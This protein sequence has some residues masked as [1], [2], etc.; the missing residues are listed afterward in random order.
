M[1]ND[2]SHGHGGGHGP[3]VEILSQMGYEAR[4]V[5]LNV[6]GR[7]LIFLGI[8]IAAMTAASFFIYKTL[9]PSYAEVEHSPRLPHV[10]TL[11]PY[12]Q[13][14]V[15][16]HR[17]IMEFKQ[18]EED[19]IAGATASVAGGAKT[20]IPISQ[21]IDQMAEKGIAGVS[22]S[23]LRPDSPAYPGSS[24]YTVVVT[25]KADGPP[26]TD[27]TGTGMSAEAGERPSEQPAE[28]GSLPTGLEPG[29]TPAAGGMPVSPSGTS[30]K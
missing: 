18:A 30:A 1:R 8:F 11:P 14:Q 17:D 5:S 7:W 26:T 4:D 25:A 20:N 22:G 23:D 29:A 19:V 16:P 28:P 27:G 15:D 9:V 3:S 2:H 13:I 12:P 24:D 21:A 6:L 10:A